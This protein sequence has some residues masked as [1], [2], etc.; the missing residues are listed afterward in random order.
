MSYTSILLEMN[1]QDMGTPINYSSLPIVR[2]PEIRDN[3]F[4][5]DTFQITTDLVIET[6]STP[7]W[8]FKLSQDTVQVPTTNLF[9]S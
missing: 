1:E 4:K 7:F 2:N 6:F 5:A 3:A 9:S 8:D